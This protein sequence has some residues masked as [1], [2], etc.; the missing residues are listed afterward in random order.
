MNASSRN[1][2]LSILVVFAAILWAV[3][4]LAHFN[5]NLNVRI[6]HV[7]HVGDGL[8]VYLRTPM[9]YLVA[10]KI[11]TVGADGLPEPAPYTT[12]RKEEARVVHLVDIAA[13]KAEPLGLGQIAADGLRLATGDTEIKPRVVRVKAYPI[14]QEPGFAT[15]SEAQA[16]LAGGLPFPDAA[17]ETYV[18]DT[19]IDV[20]LEYPTSGDIGA[21]TIASRLDPGLP[22][23]EETANLILDHGPGGTKVFRARGLLQE[24]ITITRSS[25]SAA[26]T[27]IWEGVRHILGGLDHVL[28]VLCLVLGATGL[29]SL[30]GRITGFTVGHSVTLTT[31]FLGFVP[32][33]AWFVP[34]VETGIALS[35]IYAAALALR[36][37]QDRA[38]GEQRMFFVTCAIGLL[39]GLGFSFVLHEILKVDSPNLWQ[40]LL[41]FNIGVEVGQ[42][43]IVLAV[44]PV[45]LMMRR[46]NET[47]WQVSRIS[48]AVGC[49][50]IAAYWTVQRIASTISVV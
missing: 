11:G 22:G 26:V 50:A 8:R 36:P 18:G 45:L 21:Y 9:P 7:E 17:S 13:L 40:S 32:T 24:P 27:F 10:D 39:H 37:R 44:W 35:I 43:V 12:N 29:R 41:A 28:F 16:A 42:L 4:A 3:G 47:I 20:L 23:Q 19:I 5:L 25:I 6:V 14:G 49:I 1:G 34:S 33:G 31:G 2:S 38:L 48:I 15:L 30:V 46:F